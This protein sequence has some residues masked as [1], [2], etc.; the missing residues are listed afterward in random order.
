MKAWCMNKKTFEQYCY[1]NGWNDSNPPT[2]VALISICCTGDVAR[3]VF[4]DDGDLHWFAKQHENVLNVEFDDITND[5]RVCCADGDGERYVA[6]GITPCTA[7]RIVEFID[8]HASMD[9]IV[10]CR[11]GKSRSQAV[12]RYILDFYPDHVETNPDNPPNGLHNI[13]TF[14]ALKTAREGFIEQGPAPVDNFDAV[15]KLLHFEMA[16]DMFYIKTTRRKKDTG[17]KDSVLN[18]YHV[19]SFKHFDALKPTIVAECEAMGARAMICP[20]Q[21]SIQEINLH[22]QIAMLEDQLAMQK[23]YKRAVGKPGG[24]D[25]LIGGMCSNGESS[26]ACNVVSSR[27]QFSKACGKFSSESR[28]TEKWILDIDDYLVNPSTP[29]YSSLD[30]IAD[31][32]S[33]FINGGAGTNMEVC[34]IRSRSGLHLLV[35]PFNLDAFDTAFGMDPKTGHSFVKKD[36]ML[37]LYI[38]SFK[39]CQY[40]NRQD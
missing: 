39:D 28:E 7:M 33:D 23:R 19:Q 11:A 13:H 5:V 20:N 25:K 37:N 29:G 18:E 17:C 31:T 12:I 27:R 26:T 4:P 40:G 22:V 38:P 21:R 2:D 9:F 1:E 8:A 24:M 16:G 36:G 10:H 15:R 35:H 14:S 3:H 34:R 32:W 30:S 6:Q